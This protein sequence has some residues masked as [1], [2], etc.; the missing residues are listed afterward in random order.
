MAQVETGSQLAVENSAMSK[1]SAEQDW[2]RLLF[3][4]RRGWS[5]GVLG[6]SSLTRFSPDPFFAR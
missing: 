6:K 5:R 4:E 3:R 2:V 1:S